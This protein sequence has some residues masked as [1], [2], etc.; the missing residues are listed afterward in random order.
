MLRAVQLP[1]LSLS[2]LNGKSHGDIQRTTSTSLPSL[3]TSEKLHSLSIEGSTKNTR[4]AA[5][6]VLSISPQAGYRQGGLNTLSI[7]G[8]NGTNGLRPILSN[9]SGGIYGAVIVNQWVPKAPMTVPRTAFGYV[10]TPRGKALAIGGYETN[11]EMLDNA[12]EFNQTLQSWRPSTNAM[13][14]AR[15]QLEVSLSII[16]TFQ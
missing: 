9:V 11:G 5:V 7:L 8:S 12:D 14:E 15:A 4:C 13:Q 10:T 6:Q 3:C 2:S 1:P 16:P